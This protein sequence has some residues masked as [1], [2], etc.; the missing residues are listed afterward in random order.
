MIDPALDARQRDCPD[1]GHRF[2]D[3]TRVHG[4]EK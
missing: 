4:H 1:K 3:G 2:S